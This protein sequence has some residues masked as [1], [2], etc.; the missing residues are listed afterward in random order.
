MARAR[1][2][3][4]RLA[5]LSATILLAPVCGALIGLAAGGLAAKGHG[6]PMARDPGATAAPSPANDFLRWRLVTTVRNGTRD[7]GL[8]F[9]DVTAWSHGFLAVGDSA[10]TAGHAAVYESPDGLHW[11]ELRPRA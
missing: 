7:A 9:R 6:G 1:S 5:L 2:R 8:W 3:Q 11:T 10:D 4:S